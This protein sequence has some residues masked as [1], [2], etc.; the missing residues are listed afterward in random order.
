MIEGVFLSGAEHGETLIDEIGSRHLRRGSQPNGRRL[1]GT[2]EGEGQPR[3]KRR[4]NACDQKL[5]RRV[6][7]EASFLRE[8]EEEAAIVPVRTLDA[9]VL[10]HERD[11]IEA[12]M[13]SP[14]SSAART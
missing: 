9:G 10:V 11:G 13:P 3:G 2:D 1:D 7:A 12:T 5:K 8:F 4:H 6:S 14:L